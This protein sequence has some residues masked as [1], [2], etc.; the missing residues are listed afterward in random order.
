MSSPHIDIPDPS[1]LTSPPPFPLSITPI[2]WAS[3]QIPEYTDRAAFTIANVLTPAECAQLTA[4]A[5]SSAGVE[6]GPWPPALVRGPGG[7]VHR[8]GYRNSGRIIWR[9]QTIADRIWARCASADGLQERLAVVPQDYGRVRRGE[10]RFR[11]VNDRM[12][13]LRYTA[14]QYFQPHTDGPYC[15]ETDESRFQTFYTLQ[16]YLGDSAAGGGGLVGGETSF[17]SLDRKRRVDVEP[18]AGS[19]L[20]FQHEN[21]LHEG[22]EVKEGVKFAMRTDVLYEWVADEKPKNAKRTRKF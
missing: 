16:L 14:G 20:I 19:V 6:Q 5:E 17:L 13:F 4:L 11:R 9:N 18:R 2:D 10:W 12:S 22:A 21:L 1:F 3:T 7:E 8:P 15:Y